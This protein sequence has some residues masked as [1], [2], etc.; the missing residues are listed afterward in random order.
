MLK[1]LVS[2]PVNGPWLDER[3]EE[4]AQSLVALLKCSS[5]C[6]HASEGEDLVLEIE[7]RRSEWIH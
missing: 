5:C 7:L 2:E 1:F 3:L 6:V 4:A